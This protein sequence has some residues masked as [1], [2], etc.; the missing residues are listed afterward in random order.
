MKQKICITCEKMS[1]CFFTDT[2][3]FIPERKEQKAYRNTTT[4]KDL[5]KRSEIHKSL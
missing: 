3:C 5:I 1:D 2:P 4:L